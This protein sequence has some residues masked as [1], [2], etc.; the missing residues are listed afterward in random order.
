MLKTKIL[1]ETKVFSSMESLR[2]LYFVKPKD[3]LVA[4]HLLKIQNKENKARI[5]TFKVF[6]L[7]KPNYST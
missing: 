5:D 1:V 7:T 4:V 6:S 2:K 3:A